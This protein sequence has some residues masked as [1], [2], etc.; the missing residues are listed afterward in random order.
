[1]TVHKEM[2]FLEQLFASLEKSG[3]AVV[4]QEMRDGRVLPFTARQLLDQV[5]MG[6]AY[7]RRLR[8][9]RATRFRNTAKSGRG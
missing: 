6:R 2:S 3:D 8:L 1:M 5:L 7:L 4:L 9:K